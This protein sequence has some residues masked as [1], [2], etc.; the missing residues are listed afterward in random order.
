MMESLK[1]YSE[2]KETGQGWIGTVP[3][4]WEVRPAFGVF[5][6]NH[7]KNKGLREKIVGA[8]PSKR[9]C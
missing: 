1:P 7:E 2:Y 9:V 6:E 4:H 3:A 5:Q 8:I